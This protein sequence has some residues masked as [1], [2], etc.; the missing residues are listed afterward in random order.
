MVIITGAGGSGKVEEGKER[1]NG[2]VRKQGGEHT[3]PMN[4]YCII[5][6]LSW[7]LY[8]FMNQCHSINS[9]KKYHKQPT[10]LSQIRQPL[11]V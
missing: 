9:I 4:R 11:N 5:E 8:N 7:N 3:I 1:T 2:D 10:R 6:L